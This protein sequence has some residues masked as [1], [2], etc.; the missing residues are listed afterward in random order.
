MDPLIWKLV[1]LFQ[2]SLYKSHTGN[3]LY[4]FNYR[5][6]ILQI[7][8]LIFTPLYTNWNSYIILIIKHFF[9]LS[10][11]ITTVQFT[12]SRNVPSMKPV[13][14][15]DR[16]SLTLDRC[17]KPNP[18]RGR[19]PETEDRAHNH[20]HKIDPYGGPWRGR[21]GC[22]HITGINIPIQNKYHGIAAYVSSLQELYHIV[23]Q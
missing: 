3:V 13:D 6:N 8:Q 22:K 11:T 4:H 14:I 20:R 15:M 12:I 10:S 17:K 5:Y 23:Q 19:K 16:M 18:M 1:H 2:S 7:I 21:G 9:N